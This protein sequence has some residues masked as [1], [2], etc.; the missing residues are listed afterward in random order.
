MSSTKPTLKR[1]YKTAS[2]LQAEGGWQVLLDGKTIRTPL[3]SVLVVPTQGLADA[4]AAEW[5][6]Q[7]EEVALNSMP[8]MQ[9][10]CATLDYVAPYVNDV[11]E[12][13][14]EYAA[15]DVV[16]YRA[17]EPKDL[18]ERHYAAWQPHVDWAER[19]YGVQLNL[20]H[21]IMPVPQPV[22]TLSAFRETLSSL[23]LFELT[24]VW[25]MAK[26]CSSLVLPLAVHAGK[27]TAD[28]AY[29]LSRLDETYQ[30]EQWGEDDE[31]KD[32]RESGEAEMLAIGRFLALI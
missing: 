19:E 16:C 31:A 4:I 18:A 26:H 28:N 27:I 21:S 25:L 29:S 6:M 1:F 8:I 30:N 20:T 22:K 5:N 9:F 24:A 7:G 15:T 23:P 14:T 13:A 17:E 11:I 12:E 3:K 2:V 32:K 10:S